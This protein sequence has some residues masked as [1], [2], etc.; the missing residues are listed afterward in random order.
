MGHGGCG[1]HRYYNGVRLFFALFFF[2]LAAPAAAQVPSL[3]PLDRFWT[4]ALDAPFAARPAADGERVYVPLGTGQLVAL[5]PRT[6]AVVWSVELAAEG[7]P[8]A[9]GGRVFIPAADA[10]HAL[11]AATGTLAWRL[12]AAALAAPLVHRNGWLIVSLAGG[13]IQGVRTSDGVVVWN[14]GTDSPVASAPALDGD[15]LA[16]AL[17]DGRIL[18]M[19]VTSG[20]PRW[21]RRLGAPAGSLAVSGDRIFAGTG[22]G[23]FWSLEAKDGDLDWRWRLGSRLIGAAVAD[24]E[25]VYTVGLDNVVRGFSRGSG[26]MQWNYPLPTR[27]LGGPYLAGGLL[28]ITAGD[29]GAPGLT[30]IDAATGRAAG[31]TPALIG[32]DETTRTQFA[33]DI[34]DG[35]S[36]LAVIATATTAGGWQLHGYRQ[37]FFTVGLGPIKWGRRYEVQRRLDIRTGAMAWGTR[38]P[39][40]PPVPLVPQVRF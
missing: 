26:N 5:N 40:V 30:Y 15:L 13:G 31:K 8:L 19:D 35:A 3:F 34:A 39:L 17:A 38:V 24:S 33:V 7:A 29:I 37:T 2:A 6:D 22:D 1:V 20:K 25:R 18:A 21:E 28:I 12:P 27:P 14:R 23:Y 4:H 11:D 9:A 16:A 36:P 32:V 10:I